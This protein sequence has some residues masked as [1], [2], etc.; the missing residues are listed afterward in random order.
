MIELSRADKLRVFT[1]VALT[2]GVAVVAALGVAL[3]VDLR[4]VAGVHPGEAVGRPTS[5]PGS[6][7]S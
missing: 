5:L 1:A 2:A 6:Q 3:V 7:R 4:Q